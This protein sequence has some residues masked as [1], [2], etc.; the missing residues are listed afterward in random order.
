MTTAEHSVAYF[1]NTVGNENRCYRATIQECTRVNAFNRCGNV[2]CSKRFTSGKC[3]SVDKGNTVGDKYVLKVTTIVEHIVINLGHTII[4]SNITLNSVAEIEVVKPYVL[5]H[6]DGVGKTVFGCC[7]MEC[8]LADMNYTVGNRNALDSIKT[9]ESIA[10]NC[11]HAVKDCNGF[12]SL[13]NICF[14]CLV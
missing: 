3:E 2:D 4:E 13:R 11:G 12:K 7:A 5:I 6:R 1:C 14:V 8:P 10:R 9:E